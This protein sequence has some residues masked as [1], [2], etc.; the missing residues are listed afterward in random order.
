M[1]KLLSTMLAGVA[2]L[3]LSSGV[4]AAEEKARDSGKEPQNQTQ[5]APVE[6]A[7]TDVQSRRAP[8]PT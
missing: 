7:G 8:G 6:E 1:N 3:A 2:V 4:Y 5:G